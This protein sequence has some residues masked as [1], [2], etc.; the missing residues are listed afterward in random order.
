MCVLVFVF[1]FQV[2]KAASSTLYNIFVRFSISRELNV[3][4]PREGN[5]LGETS[6]ELY[7]LVEHPPSPPFLFDLLCNHVVFDKEMIRPFFPEDTVYVAVLREPFSQVCL[8]VVGVL[9][10]IV[11]SFS[12]SSSSFASSSLSSSS[13]VFPLPYF[14]LSISR[15]CISSSSSSGDKSNMTYKVDDP[16][17]T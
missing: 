15:Y 16:D 1:V 6:H 2:H 3:M 17:M 8:Y 10:Y 11:S 5:L 14:F 7:P 13:F 9:A 12:S 4:F